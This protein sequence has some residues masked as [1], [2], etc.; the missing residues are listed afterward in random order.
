MSRI[1]ES[2]ARFVVKVAKFVGKV[3]R[4][5]T[6]GAIVTVTVTGFVA[7]EAINAVTNKGEVM[8]T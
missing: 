8:R 2:V 4:L 7:N 1:T 6:N 3:E 5:L